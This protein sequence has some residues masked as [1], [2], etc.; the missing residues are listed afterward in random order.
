MIDVPW[1]SRSVRP[2]AVLFDAS[3]TSSDMGTSLCMGRQ[4]EGRNACSSSK[5]TGASICCFDGKHL[6]PHHS[7]VVAHDSHSRLRVQPFPIEWLNKQT[8]PP[9]EWA[10]EPSSSPTGPDVSAE[11]REPV[12]SPECHRKKHRWLM[13]NGK[14]KPEDHQQARNMTLGRICHLQTEKRAT[15]WCTDFTENWNTP[16]SGE[17]LTA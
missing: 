6:S 15:H 8:V 10:S 1:H 16:T 2:S 17:W 7:E 11:P 14:A 13:W 9:A 5:T 12:I 3:A 4:D